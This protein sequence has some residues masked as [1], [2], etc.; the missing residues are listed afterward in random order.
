MIYTE[1]VDDDERK[2]FSQDLS[3]H[4]PEPT[5]P[6]RRLPGACSVAKIER[7]LHVF[8]W[9]RVR[10]VASHPCRRC[11][12]SEPAVFGY[13]E[14][15]RVPGVSADDCPVTDILVRYVSADQKDCSVE[16]GHI[17]GISANV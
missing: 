4:E 16:D 3:N 7:V 9:R 17:A 8:D 12:E 2:A 13:T 14:R 1:S 11:D 6:A 5:A 10:T 15:C